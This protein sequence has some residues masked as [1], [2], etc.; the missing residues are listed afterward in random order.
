MG[1]KRLIRHRCVQFNCDR[2]KGPFCC[3]YCGYREKNCK[4]FCQNSP[5][6]CGLID[7]GKNKK[8]M[9]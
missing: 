2:R 9:N 5:A 4:N 3:F 1:K 8:Y 6:K 7:N